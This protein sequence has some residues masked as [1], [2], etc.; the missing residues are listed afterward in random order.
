MKVALVARPFAFSSIYCSTGSLLA[1]FL[2]FITVSICNTCYNSSIFSIKF[3]HKYHSHQSYLKNQ[4][5]SKD[6]YLLLFYLSYPDV[7]DH[8][9][10]VDFVLQQS[11]KVVL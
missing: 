10:Y 7:D 2:L 4:D 11:K 6:M 3:I 1:I 8:H 5:S 9:S